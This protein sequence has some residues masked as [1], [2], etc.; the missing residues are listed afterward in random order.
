MGSTVNMPS[1]PPAPAP[2][3]P[4]QSSIDYINAMADPALQAKL[5]QSEQTYRPQYAELNLADINTYLQGTATQKGVL[6]L[7]AEANAANNQAAMQQLTAQRTQDI[8]DVTNLG[9]QATQ[10]FRSA[11]PLQNAIVNRANQY[12]QTAYDNAGTLSPEAM[13]NA[14]QQARYGGASMGRTGDTITTASEI[15]NREQAMAMRR[16]EAMQAAQMAFGMNQATAADPFQAILGRPGQNQNMGSAQSQFAA[17]M[18][19]NAGPQLFDPNAGINLGLQNQSNQANYLSNIYGA[20]ASYAGATNQGRGAMIGGALS[21]LG[22][23]GGGLIAACWVAREVYGNDNPKWMQF[24]EWLFN[25]APNWLLHLYLQEGERFA[26]FIHNKPWM[27][28]LI[29][30]WMDG[31]IANL[32]TIDKSLLMNFNRQRG[33]F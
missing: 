28:N 14:Q 6:A 2:V 9:P 22:A 25:F 5:L 29:R 19:N 32:P 3:D 13:R 18:T 10:A 8:Q 4:G 31:R 23:L 7:D 33:T 20:Q 11:D 26:A 1:A 12:A 27:K 21:G 30:R 17:G 16:Q 24:R 15:L